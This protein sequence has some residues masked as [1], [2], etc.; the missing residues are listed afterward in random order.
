MKISDITGT[1]CDN[2]KH[3]FVCKFKEEFISAQKAVSEATIHNAKP[4]SC[5]ECIEPIRLE[6]RYAEYELDPRLK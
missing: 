4:I 2:C 3:Y 6:C 5:L 1:A